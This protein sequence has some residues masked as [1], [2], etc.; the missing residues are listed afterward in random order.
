MCA[1]R[2]CHACAM[3]VCMHGGV[4]VHAWKLVWKVMCVGDAGCIGCENHVCGGGGLHCMRGVPCVHAC[5]EA[6]LEI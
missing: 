5:V 4:C 3:H 2:A 6:W 1:I